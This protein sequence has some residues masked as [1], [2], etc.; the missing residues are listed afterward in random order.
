MAK[1]PCGCG[2][3]TCHHRTVS[4]S[5]KDTFHLHVDSAAITRYSASTPRTNHFILFF[6]AAPPSWPSRRISWLSRM[7]CREA[8]WDSFSVERC[9][10][11][12]SK[13]TSWFCWSWFLYFYYLLGNNR[14]SSRIIRRICFSF[15][16]LRR[17][18]FVSFMNFLLWK[19]CIHGRFRLIK[20]RSL[21]FYF[22]VGL[23][24]RLVRS[25]LD[26]RRK[27][28]LL[29]VKCKSCRSCSFWTSYCVS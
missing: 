27:D 18:F 23:H 25:S 16:I 12:V 3:L 8:W 14:F 15:I 7:E 2:W 4:V 11:V 9:L 24:C 22:M 20:C 21:L 19:Y 29:K 5:S 13:K 10:L 1:F 26:S 17:S 6:H 28:T